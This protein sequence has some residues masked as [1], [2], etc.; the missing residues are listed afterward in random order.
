MSL[1]PN[2][3]LMSPKLYVGNL[4]IEYSEQEIIRVL[5]ENF[6][7]FGSIND[8]FLI[9][10][11][12]TNN[13]RGFGFITFDS[14]E[15]A[16]KAMIHL[17]EQSIFAGDKVL[18]IEMARARRRLPINANGAPMQYPGQISEP[19]FCDGQHM[20]PQINGNVHHRSYHPQYYEENHRPYNGNVQYPYVGTQPSAYQAEYMGVQRPKPQ[21]TQQAHYCHP[22]N[23]TVDVP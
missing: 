5:L 18:K 7:V 20:S 17:N 15:S 4:P 23:D 13:H 21:H 19:Y 10:E 6:Q 16:Y 14:I 1:A 9:R 22:S 2:N 8:C 12:G 3:Q 11:K